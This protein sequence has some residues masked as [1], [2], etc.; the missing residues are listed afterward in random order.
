LSL[1]FYRS[2]LWIGL[3]RHFFCSHKICLI[4]LYWL[5]LDRLHIFSWIR[6]FILYTCAMFGHIEL[7]LI[8]FVNCQDWTKVIKQVPWPSF[9]QI[10]FLKSQRCL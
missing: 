7:V 5:G 2:Y 4:S 10:N 3:P 6:P 8:S 9:P 1:P